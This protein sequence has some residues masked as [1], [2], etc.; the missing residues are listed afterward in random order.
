LTQTAN[1]KS[2]ICDLRYAICNFERSE[3]IGD[4][5]VPSALE[6][7][8]ADLHLM[9]TNNNQLH[10]SAIRLFAGKEKVGAWMVWTPVRAKERRSALLKN[11]PGA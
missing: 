3:D 10:P 5:V 7:L 1:S 6:G 2:Q 11:N 8:T 9:T 4:R